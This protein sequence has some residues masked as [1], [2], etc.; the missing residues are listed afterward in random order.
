MRAANSE[1][2]TEGTQQQN[3]PRM[4]S[5]KISGI[6]HGHPSYWLSLRSMGNQR[7]VSFATPIHDFC[8]GGN[9]VLRRVIAELI[10]DPVK[11]SKVSGTFILVD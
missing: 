5:Q 9:Q 3:D 2:K 11:Y 8:F 7:T 1:P 10:T 6:R 4:F